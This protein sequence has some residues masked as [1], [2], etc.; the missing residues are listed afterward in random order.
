MTYS[1]TLPH[2][3]CTLADLIR[4]L[5][6][7]PVLRLTKPSLVGR[8]SGEVL[9]MQS[10]PSLRALHEH[11][12]EK[13]IKELLRDADLEFIVTDPALSSHLFVTFTA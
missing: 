13:S 1:L 4:V 9:F 11:K 3:C 7:D 2:A 6:D 8:D 10:P 12:L 5:V